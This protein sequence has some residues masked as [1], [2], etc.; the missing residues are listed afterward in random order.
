[1]N[2]FFYGYVG[3]K[4]ALKQFVDQYDEALKS[5][6]EKKNTE[7]FISLTSRVPCIPHYAI[8]KQF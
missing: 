6:V 4:I 3:P 8:E 5:K 7:D 2:T 1:M